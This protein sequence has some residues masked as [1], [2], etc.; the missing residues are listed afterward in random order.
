MSDGLGLGL[1]VGFSFRGG[2]EGLAVSEGVGDGV[3]L[4]GAVGVTDSDGGTAGVPPEPAASSDDEP[5]GPE[6]TRNASSGASATPR[7]TEVSA[8]RRDRD[9]L[10]RGTPSGAS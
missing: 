7:A 6:N 1:R 4:G 8:I 3:G 9:H 2:F 10:A 5:T